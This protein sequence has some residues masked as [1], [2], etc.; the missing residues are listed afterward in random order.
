MI[1]S[2][3]RAPGVVKCLHQVHSL[4]GV[5]RAIDG[6]ISQSMPLKV[7][8][9]NLQHA[10]PLRDDDTGRKDKTENQCLQIDETNSSARL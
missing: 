4:F 8:G 1:S 2:Y 9:Y 7:Q 5:N 6:G 3:L 10:G